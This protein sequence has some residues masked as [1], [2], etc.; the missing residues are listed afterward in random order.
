M[1]LYNK[2]KKIL[3]WMCAKWYKKCN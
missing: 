1:K 3:S 2:Q